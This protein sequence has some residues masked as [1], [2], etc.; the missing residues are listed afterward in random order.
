MRNQRRAH[1]Q[2]RMKITSLEQW[3]FKTWLPIPNMVPDS[4]DVPSHLSMVK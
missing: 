4:N 1:Q 2:V 3:S